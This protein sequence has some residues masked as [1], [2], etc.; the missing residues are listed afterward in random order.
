MK[1]QMNLLKLSGVAA[2]V[3]VASV[4]CASSGDTAA[5]DGVDESTVS[6]LSFTPETRPHQLNKWPIEW[7]LRSIDTYTWTVDEVGTSMANAD[8][9]A[10][11]YRSSDM[12][13]ESYRSSDANLSAGTSA[14]ASTGAGASISADA[15]TGIDVDAAVAADIATNRAGS[16][17]QFSTD[18]PEGS[19]FVEAAGAESGTTGKRVI[20][21]S[22]HT[23]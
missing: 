23:R 12:N 2:L 7:N 13:A 6:A 11:S 22:P 15:D 21:H 4:G 19:V 9:N 17:A 18:L 8:V 16:S 14:G 20:R 10:G 5:M 1:K 3:A